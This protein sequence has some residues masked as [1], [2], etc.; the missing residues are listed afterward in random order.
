M[1][2]TTAE[3]RDR[4]ARMF[5]PRIEKLVDQFRVIGNCSNPSNYE[6]TRDTVAKVWVHV[7]DAMV[8][9]AEKYGL[10]IDF[11]INGLTLSEVRDSGSIASLFESTEPQ[12][13]TQ[14]ALF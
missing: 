9:A 2:Q 12:G 10:K 5:P 11:T 8:G 14:E 4:F 7:L 3:K 13:D 6:Y 1:T